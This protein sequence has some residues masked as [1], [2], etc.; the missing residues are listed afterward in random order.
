MLSYSSVHLFNNAEYGGAEKD[1]LRKR[2]NW[3]NKIFVGSTMEY[4]YYDNKIFGW[5]KQVLVDFTKYVILRI[6][7]NIWFNQENIQCTQQKF[8]SLNQILL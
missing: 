3:I 1:T 2:F 8:C 4:G 6:E 7:Q 5:S